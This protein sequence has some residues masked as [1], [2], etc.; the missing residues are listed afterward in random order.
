MFII[1]LLL[2]FGAEGKADYMDEIGEYYS[3]WEMFRH[4][5]IGL[6]LMIPYSLKCA[7]EW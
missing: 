4:C 6:L 5:G 7:K 3:F 2:I 1:G